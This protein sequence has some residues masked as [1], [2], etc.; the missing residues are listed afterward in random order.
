MTTP[1]VSEDRYDHLQA[2]KHSYIMSREAV[3]KI[4]EAIEIVLS[5]W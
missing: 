2:F 1:Y 5:T 3:E 4:L